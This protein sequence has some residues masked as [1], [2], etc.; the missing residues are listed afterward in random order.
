MIQEVE[1]EVPLGA[2]ECSHDAGWFGEE[3]PL[4][5]LHSFRK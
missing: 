3:G 4:G 2:C 5:P 1:V